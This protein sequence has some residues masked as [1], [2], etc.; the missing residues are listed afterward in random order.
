MNCPTRFI[1]FLTLLTS[2]FFFPDA[3]K[4]YAENS[5]KDNIA[6]IV[7]VD[8]SVAFVH[9]WSFLYKYAAADKKPPEGYTWAINSQKH[10]LELHLRNRID[11]SSLIIRPEEIDRIVMRWEEDPKIKG[12]TRR[13]QYS[14]VKKNGERF[15]MENYGPEPSFLT[16]KKFLGLRSLYLSGNIR[17]DGKLV[18]YELNLGYSNW[19]LFQDDK[20]VIPSEIIFP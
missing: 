9:D 14:L 2:I 20:A 12:W 4:S 5:T 15:D 18:V 19:A 13:V 16:D 7:H 1:L 3:T 10:S 11:Q 17:N 8:S 6:K